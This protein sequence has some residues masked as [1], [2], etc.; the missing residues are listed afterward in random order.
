MALKFIISKLGDFVYSFLFDNLELI[1]FKVY[2]DKSLTNK[3]NIIRA[4]IAKECKSVD[5]FF[6]D[7]GS[8][9]EAYLPYKEIPENLNVSLNSYITVQIKKEESSLKGAKLTASLSINGLFFILKPFGRKGIFVSPK[10]DNKAYFLDL[11]KDY[12]KDYFIVVRTVAKDATQ[13]NLFKDLNELIKKWGYIKSYDNVK[14]VELIS[15]ALP[16]YIETLKEKLSEIKEIIVDD[17]EI[18]KELYKTLSLLDKEKLNS[19]VLVNSARE[20]FYCKESVFLIEKLLNK[21]VWLKNGGFLVIEETEALTAID[22]NS[23]RSSCDS[24]EETALKTNL[25]ACF[26]IAKHLAL[27]NIGGIVVIDFINMKKE[28]SKA[29]VLEEIK[30]HLNSFNLR[31]T[32]MEFTKGGLLEIILPK[33]GKSIKTL[34]T[35]EC[36]SCMGKGFIK[37]PELVAFEIIDKIKNFQGYLELKINPELMS[38]LKGKV[39]ENFVILKEDK[40]IPIEYYEMVF[41]E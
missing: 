20:F 27:R 11:L 24:I 31:P 12:Q 39:N 36:S 23:G 32:L 15:K 3:E 22:V 17:I 2:D 13:E 37:R 4:K 14:R 9:K 19:L 7:I 16:S 30:R 18:Y 29:L 38:V 26:F 21:Y 25:E 40:G 33:K 8:K 41:K 5:G 35:K 10:I 6:L 34:L 1:S 28:S